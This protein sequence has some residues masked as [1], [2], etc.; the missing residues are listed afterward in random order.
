MRSVKTTSDPFVGK[1]R[2]IA[3][4]FFD[5]F[6]GPW[7]HVTLAKGGQGQTLTIE[8]QQNGVMRS[9]VRAG[10]KGQFAV[11]DRVLE[12]P[13]TRDVQPQWRAGR[14]TV[15]KLSYAVSAE[16][17]AT[18]ASAPL[19][20]WKMDVEGQPGLQ[21][22]IPAGNQRELSTG[23]RCIQEESSVASTP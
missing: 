23:F 2:E 20:A 15:W 17:M 11:G 16:D 22:K 13:V 18:F 8:S 3:T 1:Q 5:G 14:W 4:H 12:L 19:A 7:V 10:E 9:V 6:G 21:V